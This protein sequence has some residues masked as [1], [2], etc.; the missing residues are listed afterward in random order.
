MVQHALP[1]DRGVTLETQKEKM[2]KANFSLQVVPETGLPRTTYAYC[3]GAPAE[4]SKNVDNR[5]K[6]D[7]VLQPASKVCNIS[8]YD[9]AAE[10][11]GI[12]EAHRQYM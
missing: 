7:A 9:R 5:A 11:E 6:Q 8:T 3:M 1:K 4:S 10:L 2:Q 12:S